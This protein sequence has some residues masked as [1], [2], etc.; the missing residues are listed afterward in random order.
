MVILVT[1][2]NGFVG[3][4]LVRHLMARG[5]VVIA[6]GRGPDRSDFRHYPYKYL[7]MDFTRLD[8]VKKVFDR[9]APSVIVHAG[10]MSRANECET[11]KE[12]AYEVNVTG[13]K[14]LLKVSEKFKCLFVFLS[15]DFVFDG[16]KGMYTETD[17][18]NPVNYYGQTKWEAEQ[19]VQSYRYAW[20][21]IR[22]VL[23]YGS[24]VS[25]TSNLLSIVKDKL[26]NDE[27]YSIVNDQFRTPTYIEDLVNGIRLIIERKAHGIYHI[28]GEEMMTP[29]DMA[30]QVALH[31]D[32][33]INLLR[34]VNASTFPEPARRPLRTGFNIDKAKKE[35]GFS[36]IS[37]YDEGLFLALGDQK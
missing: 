16:V 9:V 31:Y 25:S 10:A 29:F 6:T 32:L 26:K 23:V 37:F 2:A 18:P 14:N 13:T 12:L 28:S 8:D 15:T 36:P 24:P 19:L 7:P 22:T 20:T 35:L 5:H 1:G 17:K 21:I 4:Y 33:D 3:Q 34:E 27:P 30:C 11:K